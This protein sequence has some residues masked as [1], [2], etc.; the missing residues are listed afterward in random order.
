M[1]DANVWSELWEYKNEVNMKNFY[2][3]GQEDKRY[4]S[5][6]CSNTICNVRS[7]STVYNKKSL[8]RRQ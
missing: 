2:I 8:Q 6:L 3:C 5:I 4:S 7:E 1:G